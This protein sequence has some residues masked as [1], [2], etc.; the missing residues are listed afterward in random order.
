[1]RAAPWNWSRTSFSGA[2]INTVSPQ[3]VGLPRS[4][5]DRRPP[6]AAPIELLRNGVWQPPHRDAGRI[7][8]RLFGKRRVGRCASPR[9][10]LTLAEPYVIVKTGFDYAPSH[11][12]GKTC[13][14]TRRVPAF[15]SPGVR[16]RGLFCNAQASLNAA[17][18][19]RRFYPTPSHEFD[20]IRLAALS[21][22]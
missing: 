21:R 7:D 6:E 11:D 20:P 3:S 17:V 5:A 19:F 4:R 10:T 2:S 9:L 12:Q 15:L 8:R 22:F 18:R 14:S 13:E 1:M 16:Y